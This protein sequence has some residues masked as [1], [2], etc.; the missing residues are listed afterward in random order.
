MIFIGIIWQKHETIG[1]TTG[2]DAIQCSHYNQESPSHV[3]NSGSDEFIKKQSLTQINY[4]SF[5]GHDPM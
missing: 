4:T 2:Y 5:C 1:C 3:S